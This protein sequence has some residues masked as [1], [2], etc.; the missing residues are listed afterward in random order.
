MQKRGSL[1]A[2]KHIVNKIKTSR[3]GSWSEATKKSKKEKVLFTRYR[4]T[5]KNCDE[6][7]GTKSAILKHV[8]TSHKDFKFKCRYCIKKYRSLA[9]RDKHEMYHKLNFRYVCGEVSTCRKGFIFLCEYTE[10]LKT[11]TKANL[12]ICDYQDCGNGYAAKRTRDSHYQSHFAKRCSLCRS[13]GGWISVRP[14]LCEYQP[15]ETTLAWYAW[16]RVE[17]YVWK[18]VPVARDYVLPSKRV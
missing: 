1:I 11:H 17:I 10:H 7:R 5:K 12:W 14:G 9:A 13:D 15:L 6:V 4:C 3:K 2:A 18:A 8:S 16:R